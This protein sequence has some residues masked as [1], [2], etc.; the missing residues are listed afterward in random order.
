MLPSARVRNSKRLLTGCPIGSGA[1]TDGLESYQAIVYPDRHHI[2]GG[3][4][5]TFTV[6][7]SNAESAALCRCV[8]A[9]DTLLCPLCCLGTGYAHV[10][11]YSL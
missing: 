10:R 11:H 3:K 7:D 8:G 2:S 1:Y 9:H 5:H 6:E 4:R